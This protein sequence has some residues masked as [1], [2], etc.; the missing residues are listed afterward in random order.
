MKVTAKERARF[1]I[2][3]R[4]AVILTQYSLK[5]QSMTKHDQTAG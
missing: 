4:P 1:D 2:I 3:L 5:Q